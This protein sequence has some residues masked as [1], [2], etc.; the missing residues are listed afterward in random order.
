ML[1]LTIEANPCFESNFHI[2]MC[3][4]VRIDDPVTSGAASAVE[5]VLLAE[6]VDLLIGEAWD[7][8]SQGH[9]V[10]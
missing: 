6:N 3:C 1:S 5:S 9:A 2:F 8:T 4:F 7:Q 10:R